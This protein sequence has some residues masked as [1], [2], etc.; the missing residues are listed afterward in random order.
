MRST[1]AGPAGLGAA[2]TLALGTSLMLP[3]IDRQ[4]G[5]GGLATTSPAYG[6]YLT[7]AVLLLLGLGNLAL[8]R[9]RPRALLA[10]R[11][12]GPGQREAHGPGA[13]TETRANASRSP[14]R[15]ITR[16][17]AGMST[18]Y[19]PAKTMQAGPAHNGTRTASPSAS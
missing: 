11:S 9:R 7:T 3:D 18:R 10:R 17:H 5:Q 15:T 14:E 16:T 8:A 6:L 2:A 1:V 12:A 19:P 4:F 13:P